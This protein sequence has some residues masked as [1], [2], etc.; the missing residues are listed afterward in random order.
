[1]SGWDELAA[2]AIEAA[3]SGR[4]PASWGERIDVPAGGVF[5]GRYREHDDGGNSGAYLLW[6]EDG[7]E[8]FLY[9]CVS[10][11]REMKREHPDVGHRV[12]ISR[13]ENYKTKFDAE[14]EATGRNY[15]VAAEPS[16]EPLPGDELPF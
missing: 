9:G 7:R 14:G 5:R 4:V 3:E 1:M 6:D 15:G 10:L 8:C 11:D 13:G 16:D 12:V 2:R